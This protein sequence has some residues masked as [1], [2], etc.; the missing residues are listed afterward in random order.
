MKNN[1][2]NRKTYLL[3]IFIFSLVNAVSLYSQSQ[4]DIDSLVQGKTYRIILFDDREIIGQVISLDSLYLKLSENSNIYKIRK[5]D[6]FKVSKSNMRTVHTLIIDAYG[7]Y[8]VAAGEQNSYYRDNSVQIKGFN[9]GVEAI[10]PLRDFRGVRLSFDY[11]GM[12]IPELSY[13]SHYG[14]EGYE[15]NEF[16]KEDEASIRFISFRADYLLGDFRTDSRFIYFFSAGAGV[17]FYHKA[18]YNSYYYRN[19]TLMSAYSY[20]EKNSTN[21]IFAIGLFGGYKISSRFGVHGQIEY[22]IIASEDIFGH[23]NSG[24]FPFKLGVF[25]AF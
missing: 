11:T 17:N 22:N 10:L 4:V 5:D 12:K 18:A 8:T 15:Y 9:S 13:E 16:N 25:Y 2:L 3:L 19:D 7:G 23:Y 6:I 24:H 14:Y 21:I 20:P 1:P